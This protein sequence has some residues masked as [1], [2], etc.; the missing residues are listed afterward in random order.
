MSTEMQSKV[1]ASHS[2]NF[3]PIQ[4]GLL[5]RKCALCNTPGL[6]E[7]SERDEEKLTLKHSP[8]DRVEP[9]AVPPIM[10]EVL[11]SPGQPLDP[12]T[13]AF[14]EPRF[15]HDFSLVSIFGDAPVIQ[16]KLTIGQPNDRYEQEADKVAEQVMRMQNPPI[17]WQ[18]VRNNKE[19]QIQTN[20]INGQ[21][22]HI[23]APQIIEDDTQATQISD[24]PVGVDSNTETTIHPPTRGGERLPSSVRSFYEERFGY[25]F[26]HIRLHTGTNAERNANLLNARAFTLFNDIYFGAEGNAVSIYQPNWLL[27]HELV[28][29]IQQGASKPRKH[30]ANVANISK[31][32][33]TYE[34]PVI[35]RTIQEEIRREA[36]I[37]EARRPEGRLA[38][39]EARGRE[40]A[41]VIFQRETGQQP[42]P[43]GAQGVA[44]AILGHVN[45][46]ITL[47][48]TARELGYH[49]AVT[50]MIAQDLSQSNATSFWIAF[51]GNT[52][53]AL[54][55]LVPLLAPG[56]VTLPVLFTAT[57][58]R[59]LIPSI[60]QRMQTA[61]NQVLIARSGAY[62]TA[63]VGLV[64]AQ[65]AQWSGGGPSA[66]S[67]LPRTRDTIRHEFT[68][69]NSTVTRHL[70]SE[71]VALIV[72]L[73]ETIPQIF[74]N[75]GI[76]VTPDQLESFIKSVLMKT[77]FHELDEENGLDHSTWRV[78]TDR[79]QTIARLSLLQTYIL[80]YG[81]IRDISLTGTHQIRERVGAEGATSALTEFG[82]EP[83]FASSLH[84]DYEFVVGNILGALSDWGCQHGL[85]MND[86]IQWRTTNT[87]ASG[88]HSV[89]FTIRDRNAFANQLNGSNYT[90]ISNPL[91][92]IT[93]RRRRVQWTAA[94]IGTSGTATFSSSDYISQ[95]F[96]GRTIYGL[97][98]FRLQ[99][100]GVGMLTG[101][102][103]RS[104]IE[105]TAPL[106][107]SVA[108][109]HELWIPIGEWAFL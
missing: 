57:G 88:S 33:S 96:G 42:L 86:E 95:N 109:N 89:T 58:G 70:R 62:A 19:R 63:A 38:A 107:Q 49:N 2:Q 80:R 94:H 7:D 48:E 98:R 17:Q 29:I 75:E 67:R 30:R 18:S 25:D 105:P 82:G 39:L 101:L 5:Q 3:T 9:S 51:A 56:A 79:A 83:A 23:F 43:S 20:Q 53:W 46:E 92:F 65:M 90:P 31:I 77:L 66:A 41:D 4:T 74:R 11:Q 34:S 14:M 28:H 52:M 40:A 60:A 71:A 10:H 85:S 102:I 27:A 93:S 61:I 97:E 64:G 26:S 54:S 12:E 104:S 81:A 55:G 47:F 15:E 99:F 36:G 100:P 1:Q 45:D 6:V 13:R 37:P 16:A 50:Q 76:P 72:D 103:E 87:L 68:V 73:L 84:G 108:G 106:H 32:D 44:S 59:L 78:R 24:N 21:I 91:A 8:V 69:A 35:Q 22:S